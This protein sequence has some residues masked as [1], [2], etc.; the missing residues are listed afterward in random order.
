MKKFHQYTYG[1]NVEDY[2]DHKPL[3][4]I[5]RKPLLDVS[6]RLLRMLLRLQQYDI[7]I[8]YVPGRL[9][10]LAELY[11]LECAAEGYVET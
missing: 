10:H 5:T 4:T 1:R 7:N 6:N 8:V 9:M 3:K 2:S 11:L